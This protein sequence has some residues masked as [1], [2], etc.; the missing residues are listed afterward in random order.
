MRW[1]TTAIACQEG[2]LPGQ[3]G[4]RTVVSH[5]QRRGP[6]YTPVRGRRTEFATI[7]RRRREYLDERT[8]AVNAHPERKPSE[9]PSGFTRLARAGAAALLAAT[10][11][12]VAF[13]VALAMS[14][15][16]PQPLAV[17]PRVAAPRVTAA[18]RK[19]ALT[20]ALMQK[21]APKHVRKIHRVVALASGVTE[22]PSVPSRS[23]EIDRTTS[24]PD[25]SI[26]TE[27]WRLT[28]DGVWVAKVVASYLDGAGVRQ[29]SLRAQVSFD[30]DAAEVVELDP[31]IEQ[32]PSAA[33]IAGG[34]QN[35]TVTATSFAPASGSATLHLSAPPDDAASFASVAQA[36]GP[37][38]VAVGWSALDPALGVREY[39]VYRR[40]S[41]AT[42]DVLIAVVSPNGHSWRDARVTPATGYEYAVTAELTD[43]TVKTRP[44][45]VQTPSEMADTTLSALSGKG[46]FLFFSPDTS[47]VNSY[48][49]FDPSG[50]IA[51]A[52]RAGIN[53]IEVRL[54]RGTFFE[55]AS[56]ESNS[57][58]NHMIDAAA[59][60][61]IKLIAW[62]VP[63]RNTAEDVAESVAM[64][65]YRTPA[66]N[67]FVGLALD[68][69]SGTNYMGYRDAAARMVDYMEMTRAAVGPDYLLVATVMSPRLTGWTNE[70]YPYSRIA[71]YAS[72]MQPMEYWH[73][74]RGAHEYAE[75]DV[76][77]ACADAVSL[78]R[79]LAG[80]D[81]PVN[82]AGQSSDLGR[83][84]APAPG[85]LASCLGGAQAA[86]ALGETFFS[87]Q[88][89]AADQ[90]AA[91]EAY[92]W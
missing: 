92:R 46:M 28:A 32:T 15:P 40:E 11:S 37:H 42:R 13:G 72:A 61:G 27:P 22:S 48:A 57:W 52:S 33:V 58:L 78:T 65:R 9:R 86:G 50:V 39:K 6:A 35:V 90:W 18:V 24:N 47:D 38:L 62:T 21:P 43:G 60:A 69:E 70:Q 45:S 36:I 29:P 80:R 83:T 77:G 41:G 3:K 76:S 16:P 7:E 8:T 10:T 23:S 5:Y 85:E 53:E 73:H 51:Q 19:P 87:W 88:G 79:S 56:P 71:R 14:A 84:G 49:Q 81:V 31:W 25:F 63:R 54:S 55:A 67:G 89:T 59:A 68:L 17:Q 66:G 82:V 64:A 30:A 91:I 1:R 26:D 12:S 20:V 4:E 34:G 44:A 75:T 74:Y 2:C